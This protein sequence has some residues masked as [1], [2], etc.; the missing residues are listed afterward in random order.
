MNA[1]PGKAFQPPARRITIRCKITGGSQF[2]LDVDP[3]STVQ[4]LKL[5]LHNRGLSIDGL[6]V[7]VKGK[8]L[9]DEDVLKDFKVAPG[10]KLMLLRGA[11]TGLPVD[12]NEAADA[13]EVSMDIVREYEIPACEG[14]AAE[15]E[16]FQRPEQE[17]TTHCWSCA[18]HIGL[19]GIQCR[20]GYFFCQQHRMAESHECSFDYKE[21]QRHILEKQLLGCVAERV[22]TI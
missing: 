19:A 17:D 6:R 2:D 18:K 10:C 5:K 21:H 13:A 20:C 3:T 15:G 8:A 11:G 9:H 16:A 14:G 22:D 1:V 7:I 4:N 12:E